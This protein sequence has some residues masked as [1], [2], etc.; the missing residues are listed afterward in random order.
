[1]GCSISRRRRQPQD[2]EPLDRA[3][4]NSQV[5]VEYRAR[6]RGG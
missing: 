3:L 2:V 5:V 1:M 6:R 4:L